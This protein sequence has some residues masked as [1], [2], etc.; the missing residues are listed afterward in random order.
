MSVSLSGIGGTQQQQ[1]I[2]NASAKLQAAIASIVSG[3]RV[4][5]ASDDVAALSIAGQ[6]QSE[7]AGLRQISGN[8][9]QASSL[10]QVADGGVSQIQNALTQLQSLASQ[11]G[12]P[13]LNA[14][15]RKQL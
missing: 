8:L 9:A 7:T 12:N 5:Q 15:N 6:L 3:N 14:E 4:N 11:A 1:T 2:Q 13:T 10:T